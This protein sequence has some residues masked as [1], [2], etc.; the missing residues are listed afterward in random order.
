MEGRAEK[1][2]KGRIE[3][4]NPDEPACAVIAVGVPAPSG[5]DDEISR[6][7]VHALARNNRV[8]ALALA[9]KRNAEGLW[10]CEGAI[11]QGRMICKPAYSVVVMNVVP[12]NLGFSSTNTRG[13]A[14]SSLMRRAA[15]S[16]LG[17][18]LASAT[19]SARN[20]YPE[21]MA[22][23]GRSHSAIASNA[24]RLPEDVASADIGSFI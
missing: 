2:R 3:S 10:R 21:I 16:S 12:R 4:V 15:S 22:P 5:R 6:M 7:H 17:V 18:Q 1:S 23:S 20:P 14:F 11:S 13:S 24:F 19:A 8:A 9:R